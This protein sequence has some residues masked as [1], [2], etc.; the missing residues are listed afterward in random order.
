MTNCGLDGPGFELWHGQEISSLKPPRLASVP[1]QFPIQRVL[2]WVAVF[3]S[4]KVLGSS[5]GLLTG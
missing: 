3:Y 1:T 2:E 5:L 4:Q